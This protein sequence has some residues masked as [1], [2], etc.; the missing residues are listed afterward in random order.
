[1]T[2]EQEAPEPLLPAPTP[3]LLIEEGDSAH[4]LLLESLSRSDVLAQ[5]GYAGLPTEVLQS[6]L[7]AHEERSNLL[8][9]H[10]TDDSEETAKFE[11]S[12]KAIVEIRG[13]LQKRV[14]TA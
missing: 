2:I 10:N 5:S 7:E 6:L 11:E 1:M 4:E 13:E 9:S 14:G 3:E 12:E 8:D